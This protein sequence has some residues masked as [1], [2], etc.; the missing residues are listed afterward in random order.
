MKQGKRIFALTLAFLLAISGSLSADAV[1]VR[2]AN[3]TKAAK[4]IKV[5][6]VAVA[7]CNTGSVTIAKGKSFTLKP[8]VMPSNASNKK[9]SYTS[10]S[11][12]V[13][14]V[15][16]KGK[17]TAKKTGKAK[18]TVKAKD[19][20]KKKKTV[21]VKVVEKKKYKKATNIS[22]AQASYTVAV[23]A[24]VRTKL[25]FQPSAVSNKNVTYKTSNKKVASVDAKGI[26][27]GEKS[28]TAKITA[29]VTDGSKKKATAVVTVKEPGSQS[30]AS[31][32]ANSQA[33]G[34]ETGNSQTSSSETKASETPGGE[35]GNSQA[36]GDETG[37]SQTSSSETK[38]SETPG[39][40]TGNSQAIGSETPNSET[41][42]A[43][44]EAEGSEMGSSETGGSETKDS[45]ATS[46]ETKPAASEIPGS[47]AGDSEVSGSEV[48][49]SETGGS[50]VPGS[51]T[52]G[53]EIGSSETAGSEMGSSETG[54][55]ETEMPE[56]MFYAEQ[57][58]VILWNVADA[59]KNTHYA[60]AVDGMGEVAGVGTQFGW[61]PAEKGKSV[62]LLTRTGGN[63]A[64]VTWA[65]EA[66]K[67]P[68][69][70][71]HV[72]AEQAGEYYFSF[73]ANSPDEQSDSFHLFVNDSYCF[74]TDTKEVI[75]NG[76]DT[77]G[78][79]AGERWY[80]CNLK[81]VTL[82]KG[83]NSVKIAA[84]EPGLLLRQLCLSRQNPV[85]IYNQ[86]RR[87]T[88]FAN[89]MLSLQP[90]DRDVRIAYGG[91]ADIRVAASADNGENVAVS[92][93]NAHPEV[94]TAAWQDG[95][96]H[97]EAK[98]A[99]VTNITVTAKANGCV[100]VTDEIG[101]TVKEQMTGA[102]QEGAPAD[103]AAAY[104][105]ET[106]DAITITW[107]KPGGREGNTAD[108]ADVTGYR[109]YCNGILIGESEPDTTHYTASGLLAGTEYTFVV[110]AVRAA[111]EAKTAELHVSTDPVGE[112]LN[113]AEYGASPEK[114]AR[115]NAIAIQK[116]ID[117][118]PE[119]GTVYIPEGTYLSGAIDLKSN[120]TLRV[121]GVLK[122]ST[123]PNDYL[124][125]AGN[126][127]EGHVYPGLMN[128]DGLIYSRYEGW[129]IYCYR[130][131]INVGYI[132][133]ANRCEVTCENVT[134]CGAGEVNGGGTTLL[135]KCTGDSAIYGDGTRYP[136]YVSD[137]INSR[138]TRGRLICFNQAKDVLVKE[139]GIKNPPCWT[140]HMI[141]CDTMS[142][143][144]L[145]IYSTGVR[146]GDG[147]DPD[148]S[149]NLMIFD[150]EFETG[151]DC[152]AIK[153]GK[154]PDGNIVNLPT[155]NIRIFDLE[156]N[157]G[158]G[159]A[160]GSEQSGGVSNV[161]IRDLKQGVTGH[162]RYGLEL[163]AA[164]E[165]GG[166]IKDLVVLDSVL[167]QFLAH[168]VTYNADGGAAPE[169][170]VFSGFVIRNSS[171]TGYSSGSALGTVI[172]LDGFASASHE[173]VNQEH[174][175][176]DLTFDHVVLGEEDNFVK[177]VSI[178]KSHDI[179]FLNVTQ[180][181]GSAP[182][183]VLANTVDASTI[184]INNELPEFDD[185]IEAEAMLSAAPLH[186]GYQ[187][188]AA[189]AASGG[190]CAELKGKSTDSLSARYSGA[191]AEAVSVTYYDAG[192]AEYALYLADGSAPVQ[193]WTGTGTFVWTEKTV[194]LPEGVKTGTVIRVEAKKVGSDSAKIDKVVVGKAPSSEND[195]K[196]C[197]D[198]NFLAGRTIEIERGATVND[199]CGRITS[200]LGGTQSY[201]VYASGESAEA[202]KGTDTVWGNYILRVTSQDGSNTA[203]YKLVL[204]IAPQ[205]VSIIGLATGDDAAQ[206]VTSDIIK[207]LVSYNSSYKTVKVD[208]NEGIT[209]LQMSTP[210]SGDV[211]LFQTPFA[212]EEG[213]YLPSIKYKQGKARGTFDILLV[214]EDG[215][216]YCLGSV[217]ER[218]GDLIAT[219]SLRE[220]AV[221][222]PAGSYR[223][224]ARCTVAGDLTGTELYLKF[225]A[226][227]DAD[228]ASKDQQT[229]E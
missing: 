88:G 141:Y 70:T 83:V 179:S 100:T 124:A 41:K 212:V 72:R 119:N 29:T 39:G 35:T 150:C 52:A 28:G 36:P 211:I 129:E 99:G 127:P 3:G 64:G 174:Y 215:S 104:A 145:D 93:T 34:D 187:A 203:D 73:Y 79:S 67:A 209:Y 176:H 159:M 27:K 161:Y 45:Q 55:S 156:M 132:N 78:G 185:V 1:T 162:T 60:K 46:S 131:L 201:A 130:S 120:M 139:V 38:A 11:P 222:I 102:A 180:A 24:K 18:I 228:A 5:T 152:I 84:C 197:L 12:K 192:A 154:N 105:G 122:G 125:L 16:Q 95:V 40:E 74:S 227:Y 165:R 177:S 21:T 198:G 121:D 110:G 166:Y 207:P 107:D 168:S 196:I 92:L 183:Y 194:V 53:S 54:G 134:I 37:N 220:E 51:E 61:Q 148:S 224:S 133:Q 42:P 65:K 126:Y 50:E 43:D 62:Q 30:G 94:A 7:N 32:T 81:K 202:L 25:T 115:E 98:K 146:N 85:F 163:K 90:E 143:Y 2:A 123:D 48:G 158:L 151:D 210:A 218:K 184:R 178:A 223:L 10:S 117:A 4:K 182:K 135:N 13:A 19:G 114:T 87:T 9:V 189:A 225:A 144:G 137:K 142:F 193:T 229:F 76:S 221:H 149:R 216:A 167:D 199:L 17:I 219:A 97:V 56:D 191:A 75:S 160:I 206:T 23:G 213:G 86:W 171:I 66:D 186:D 205:T 71:Y 217:D 26:V 112:L 140:L 57:A 49:G 138:R 77:N 20:S 101:I 15:S 8:A 33:P 116:A 44:S 103:L 164:N 153:S 58:G 106:S 22:F 118:C 172:T 69:L 175:I 173:D 188:S 82:K 111:G 96:L 113:I 195:V 63:P 147:W 208:T 80:V 59:L 108:Y 200:Y 14:A 91:A 190:Y 157:G 214:A 128:D 136:E 170:P 68:Y 6:A 169:L 31:E 47:E 89:G 155:E 109:I 181:N 204:N 226:P